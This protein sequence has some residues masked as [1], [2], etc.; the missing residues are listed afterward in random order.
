MDQTDCLEQQIHPQDS[1][2]GVIPWKVGRRGD[3]FF[4]LLNTLEVIINSSWFTFDK[5]GGG[6]VSQE[7]P[8][9]D[10]SPKCRPKV[11]ECDKCNP[12]TEEI[13]QLVCVLHGFCFFTA[14]LS[15]FVL[16]FF[17]R[18]QVLIFFLRRD[19]STAPPSRPPPPGLHCLEQRRATGITLYTRIVTQSSRTET[20]LIF[21]RNCGKLQ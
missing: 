18:V 8:A 17:L 1:R 2:H 6:R 4:L 13:E 12:A 9:L 20:E 5:H 21:E 11:H 16:F 10:K 19:V 3:G 14:F 15:L 7:A